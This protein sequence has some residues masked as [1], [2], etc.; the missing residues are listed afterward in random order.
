MTIVDLGSNDQMYEHDSQIDS[1]NG[2]SATSENDFVAS[3]KEKMMEELGGKVDFCFLTLG[4]TYNHLTLM[5]SFF[6]QSLN[7]YGVL[8]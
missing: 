8:F 6:E 5:E 2:R 3:M 1:D 7:P 4:I